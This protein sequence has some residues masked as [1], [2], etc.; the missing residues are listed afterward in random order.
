MS[1]VGNEFNNIINGNNGDNFISGGAGADD[2]SGWKG[3]DTYVVDNP[4]DTLFENG[5]V[6]STPENESEGFDTVLTFVS[7]DVGLYNEIEVLQAIGTANVN[8]TGSLDDNLLIGNDATNVLDGSYGKDT[9]TGGG[10]IDAFLWKSIDEIGHFNFDPDIVTDFSIA[11]GDVLHFTNIDA[12]ANVAGN[13]DFTF[14]GNAAFTGAGQIN[15]FTDGANTFIQLNT[16]ADLTVDGV[17]QLNGV[18]NGDA[19]LMFL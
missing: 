16:D 18:T 12:N 19:V 10:G 1:L 7:F 3:N 8:L 6:H 15:W 4:G 5:D 11:Q 14:I 2:M 17:I 9:L 13:Q